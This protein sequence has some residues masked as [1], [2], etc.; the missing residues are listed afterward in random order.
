M[1]KGNIMKKI[2]V[3]FLLILGACALQ[4]KHRGYVFPD[5]LE[6]KVATI[7][8]TKQLQEELKHKAN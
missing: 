8:T 3:L 7:K 5:D 6:S 4:T 1:A 2:F